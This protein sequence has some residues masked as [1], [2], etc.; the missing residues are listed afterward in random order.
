M[1]RGDDSPGQ[2]L[3]RGALEFLSWVQQLNFALLEKGA[4]LCR[5][6]EFD[7]IHAHDWLVAYAGKGLNISTVGR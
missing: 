6:G 5:R 3:S 1:G 2:A 7:L 4:A